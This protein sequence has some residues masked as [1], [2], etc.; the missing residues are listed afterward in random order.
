MKNALKSQFS[1]CLLIFT[2][3]LLSFCVQNSIAAQ[4]GYRDKTL[5][6]VM[7][8]IMRTKDSAYVKNSLGAPHTEK[9]VGAYQVWYWNASY[10]QKNKTI[11]CTQV[12]MIQGKK[13]VGWDTDCNRE[14]KN[15]MYG[16]IAAN[17]PV[18]AAV[19][20]EK[21]AIAIINEKNK[22]KEELA[23]AGRSRKM[24]WGDYLF[25]EIGK[26]EEQV[27]T[28]HKNLISSERLSNGKTIKTYEH[29]WSEGGDCFFAGD[30][31]TCPSPS[32]MACRYG[33]SFKSGVVVGYDAG[34]CRKDARW[35]EIPY[36]TPPA[37]WS[38]L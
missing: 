12:F 31:V 5:S 35:G 28:R 8:E 9:T 20:P 24:S 6:D 14:A 3:V 27:Y 11:P 37:P 38:A 23:F 16:E 29:K 7:D 18:P 15:S 25:A 32:A 19:I 34:D 33:L 4:A 2:L 10:K 21:I 1:L 30:A 26:N 36:A 13:I 17:I 22:Q